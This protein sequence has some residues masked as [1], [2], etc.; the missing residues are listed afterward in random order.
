MEPMNHSR[1][2]VA[3]SSRNDGPEMRT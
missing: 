3:C 1:P 2:A